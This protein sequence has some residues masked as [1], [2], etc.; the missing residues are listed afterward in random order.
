[1]GAWWVVGLALAAASGC[2]A[3]DAPDDAVDPA[4]AEAAPR[5][6]SAGEALAGAYLPHV[7]PMT[8]DDAEVHKII[9]PGAYCEFRYTSS[10]RPV[11]GWRVPSDAAPAGAVVKLNGALVGLQPSSASGS[12]RFADGEVALTLTP[13]AG[14][15]LSGTRE[16]RL[17]FAVGDRL[18]VGYVG[19]AACPES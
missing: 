9:G 15:R 3:S 2:S 17:V 10:G 12:T 7:D 13:P 14:T 6:A 11:L 8:L 5:I 16:A 18:E 19:Y 1:M 4:R